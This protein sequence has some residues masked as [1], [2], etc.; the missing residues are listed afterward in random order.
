MLNSGA[1]PSI[2]TKSGTTLMDA[3]KIIRTDRSSEMYG[4]RNKVVDFLKNGPNRKGSG[5]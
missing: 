3:M 1:D 4:W 2:L 5:R